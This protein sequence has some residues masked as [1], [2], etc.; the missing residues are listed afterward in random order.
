[1]IKV[2]LD[3]NVLVSALG[4][5]GPEAAVI[6]LILDGAIGLCLSAEILSEFYRVCQYPKLGFSEAEVD[7]FTGRLLKNAEVVEPAKKM[8]VIKEDEPDNRLLE[9]AVAGKVDFIIS[10]DA[11]LL[12]L[13][14]IQEIKILRAPEFLKLY[15]VIPGF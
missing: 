1:M 2:C 4:W 12:K 13:G 10:G 11:H 9:C 3:T 7:G 15:Q 6:S 8:A 5:P 14:S